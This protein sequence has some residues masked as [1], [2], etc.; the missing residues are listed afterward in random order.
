M[1]AEDA[2]LAANLIFKSVASVKTM[3]PPD[4]DELDYLCLSRG[5]FELILRDLLLVLNYRVEVYTKPSTS[6]GGR[7]NEWSVEFKASPGNLTAF[8]SLLFQNS[9][10][11]NGTSVVGL[12]LKKEGARSVS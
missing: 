10:M 8:E 3:A 1:H 4:D 2:H 6:T 12:F 11:V 5:N 7:S 9:E